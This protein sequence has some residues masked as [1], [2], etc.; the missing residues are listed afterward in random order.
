[1]ADEN[2]AMNMLSYYS[3]MAPTVRYE[4]VIIKSQLL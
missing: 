1:M 3:Y 2:S 4:D